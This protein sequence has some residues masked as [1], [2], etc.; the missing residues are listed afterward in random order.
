MRMAPAAYPPD[1]RRYK[2][3]NTANSI[4]DVVKQLREEARLRKVQSNRVNYAVG[5]DGDVE[6]LPP[7]PSVG[8]DEL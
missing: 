6:M 3:A 2:I 8:K 4:K 1:A 5:P 7:L